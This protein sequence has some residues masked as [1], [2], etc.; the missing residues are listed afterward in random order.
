MSF[1][2]GSTTASGSAY[3]PAS[4]T[5]TVLVWVNGASGAGSAT[6]SAQDFGGT[7]M[8]EVTNNDQTVDLAGNGDPS[9]NASYLVSPGTTSQTLSITWSVSRSSQNGYA[10]TVDGVDSVASTDGNNYTADASPSLTYSA[11]NGDTVVY[12][13]NHARGG[14]AIS[15]TD[16]T[17]FTR[18]ASLDLITS[19]ARRTIAIWTRD[20]TTTLSGVSVSATESAS[21]DGVHGVFVLKAASAD[22]SVNAT[23][24]AVVLAK[25]NPFVLASNIASLINTV[26]NY[27][28]QGSVGNF[29]AGGTNTSDATYRDETD[30]LVTIRNGGATADVYDLGV[31]GTLVK[32][33]TLNFDGSDCEGICD[34]GGGEFA[35]C[36]EDGGRYQVNIY[37]WPSDVGTTANSKQE[38]TLAAPGT[39]NNSGAEGVCYDRKNK[40]FYVVGEGEQTST[41]REFFKVLRPGVEGR[42]GDTTTSYA[43]NDADDGDGWSF[44]DYVTQPWDPEVEFASYG[45]TGAAFDLSSI[46]F[47]HASDNIVIASD[48]GQKALQVDVTDGSVVAEIDITSLS[49]MEGVAILPD[50][51]IMFMG[52]A[53]EY[54]IFESVLNISASTDTIALA[55]FSATVQVSTPTNITA[56]LDTV[57]LAELPATVE[58]LVNLEVTATLDTISLADFNATVE[59]LTN[60]NVTATLDAVVLASSAATVEAL[61]NT[62]VSATLDTISL[63]GINPVVQFGDDVSF[64][65]SLDTISISPLAASVEALVNLEVSA[66]VDNVALQGYS[67]SIGTGDLI[68]SATVDGIAVSPLSATVSGSI[69]LPAFLGSGVLMYSLNE[70]Y[71]EL[72]PV[73]PFDSTVASTTYTAR[74]YDLVEARTG[75]IY[76]PEDPRP[77]DAVIVASEHSQNVVVFGNGNNI[78]AE[79]TEV[80]SVTISQQGTSLHFQY[81]YDEG[82]WRIV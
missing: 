30:E 34:M 81:F 26:D 48:T 51:E 58:A 77:F 8:S 12:W 7:S 23:T 57:A 11:E 43:Y 24:D 50:G 21:G 62:N 79:G 15:W 56:T 65:A 46:D 36:S 70:S 69:A 73:R 10:F 1:V 47:D 76:L 64:T 42:S 39:D 74:A 4:G 37:D 67:A 63:A 66:T 14:G 55:T 71:F 27:V 45:A 35:T 18:R 52:E 41:D 72:N 25:N 60:T 5:D 82:Y 22:T 16:P 13:R 75:L 19:P 40:I 49:Q 32:T 54:Q 17:S 3:A 78:K 20:V 61:T 28:A 38:L 59:A 2:S 80:T 44:D 53:D 31:Y 9:G 6:G 29:A 33:I 68:V